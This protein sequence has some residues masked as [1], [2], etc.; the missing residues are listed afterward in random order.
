MVKSVSCCCVHGSW[1][2]SNPV[3]YIHGITFAA[4]GFFDIRCINFLHFQLVAAATTGEV[5][6]TVLFV[7]LQN[8]LSDDFA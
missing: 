6:C 8:E 7:L 2:F 5:L 1:C 3:T 4:P